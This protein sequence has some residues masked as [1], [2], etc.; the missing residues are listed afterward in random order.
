MKYVCNFIAIMAFS[1]SQFANAEDFKKIHDNINNRV[2][3]IC[4]VDSDGTLNV[5]G[6][7]VYNLVDI[8]FIAYLADPKLKRK[9]TE[10]TQIVTPINTIRDENS[11]YAIFNHA[12]VEINYGMADG[13]SN[14]IIFKTSGETLRKY[15]PTSGW[16]VNNSELATEVNEI[17]GYKL[18]DEY[19]LAKSPRGYP[20]GLPVKI[21]HL[22]SKDR[23][24]VVDTISNGFLGM[25]NTFKFHYTEFSNL[26]K[27]ETTQKLTLNPTEVINTSPPGNEIDIKINNQKAP[28]SITEPADND[29]Y[30]QSNGVSR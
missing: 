25:G 28:K 20:N 12:L 18:G 14:I 9:P 19:C 7:C 21:T 11:V 1:I 6:R 26:T 5:A 24:V 17:N 8:P 10:V 2:V 27:C 15:S 23:Y 29:N 16:L 4:S 30:Q 13:R 22:F 3:E